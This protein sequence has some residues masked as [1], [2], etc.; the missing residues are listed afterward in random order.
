MC[1]RGTIERQASTC[2]PCPGHVP[3][4]TRMV[5]ARGIAASLAWQAVPEWAWANVWACGDVGGDA[6]GR[7][8]RLTSVGTSPSTKLRLRHD[9]GVLSANRH[10]RPDRE[11]AELVRDAITIVCAT[12]EAAIDRRRRLDEDAD[13]P[14]AGRGWTRTGSMVRGTG[15]WSMLAEVGCSASNVPTYNEREKPERCGA[16]LLRVPDLK[17]IVFERG[18]EDR[19]GRRSLSVASM[20]VFPS[21]SDGARGLGLRTSMAAT[22]LSTDATHICQMDADLCT[23]PG[24]SA[25]ARQRARR[26]RL[27]RVRVGGASRTGRRGDAAEC[28]RKRTCVRQGL[29]I[30]YDERLSCWRRERCRDTTP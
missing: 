26:H 6:L 18:P 11:N 27:G 24:H 29:R 1:S 20:A 17:V 22:N 9:R 4:P 28:L 15:S 10:H 23:I 21:K 16:A 12:D 8:R 2:H 30:T 13:L 5:I 7:C 3:P 25:P 14:T 19:S